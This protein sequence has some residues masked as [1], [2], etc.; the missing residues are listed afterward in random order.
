MSTRELTKASVNAQTAK[1]STHVLLGNEHVR[2]K[3]VLFQT[4]TPLISLSEE[5]K[6][7]RMFVDTSLNKLQHRTC[8]ERLFDRRQSMIM[9]NLMFSSD[10]R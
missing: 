5:Q 8:W 2:T 6:M 3:V 10:A 4:A 1:E 9:R 7:C